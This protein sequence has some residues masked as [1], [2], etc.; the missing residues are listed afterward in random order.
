M[1][2]NTFAQAT[3]TSL[4]LNLVVKT[5][6]ALMHLIPIIIIVWLYKSLPVKLY[7]EQVH[8]Q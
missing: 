8:D 3:L 5:C 7:E 1:V 4:M 2:S 6:T